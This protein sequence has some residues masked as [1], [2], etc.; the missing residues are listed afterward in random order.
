MFFLLSDPTSGGTGKVT[1][2]RNN[3]EHDI[4]VHNSKKNPN[5]GLTMELKQN[6]LKIVAEQGLLPPAQILKEMEKVNLIP[7]SITNQAGLVTQ[8]NNYLKYQGS[9]TALKQKQHQKQ[10]QQERLICGNSKRKK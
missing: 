9:L 5:R 7:S 2:Y 1:C 6:V 10:L 4:N 3:E 8:I